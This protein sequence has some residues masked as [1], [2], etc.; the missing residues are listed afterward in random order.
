MKISIANTLYR[1][2]NGT[3][4]YRRLR[5][6]IYSADTGHRIQSPGKTNGERGSKQDNAVW[7]RP[8]DEYCRLLLNKMIQPHDN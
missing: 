4:T 5:N 7:M 1:C 8:L 2:L 3:P 6:S